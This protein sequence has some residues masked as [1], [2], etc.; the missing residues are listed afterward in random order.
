MKAI[1][2]TLSNTTDLFFKI[3][4]SRGKNITAQF[5]KAFQEN[6]DIALRIAQWARDAR[7]G[8]GERE[9]YRQVL[10]HLEQTHTDV[11]LGTRLLE[12]TAEI[13]RWDDLLIFTNAEVKA[14]AFGMI[15]EALDSGNGLCAKWMPRKGPIALEL[16]TFLGWSPKYYRKRLV[17]LT[18]VVETQMCAKKWDEINFSHVPSLA[19]SRYSKAFGKNASDSFT[20]FKTKLKSGDKSVKVNAGAVYPYDITKNVKYGDSGLADEQWKA[21]PNFIGDAMVLPL[22]D[23]SGSMTT[24]A[25]G[26]NS[27]SGV[28]CLDVAV[29]LGLYCSDKNTGPFKDL[30]LTFSTKPKF[31][32]LTGTLSQK[33]KQMNTSNWE[34]STNLHGAF[35]EI[36][37]VAKT[38]DVAAKDMPQVLLIMSDMQFNQCTRFD[39]SAMQMIRRKYKDAGYETPQVVF[40]NL[41]AA[42]NVPVKF[43]EKGVALV[44]GF[45]PSIMKSV[46]AADMEGFTP[47]GIMKKA[48][49]SDRYAL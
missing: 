4:A 12:N 27:K 3:G 42:D 10:K 32:H 45:S 5:E 11:L 49:M 24:P 43:D 15:K 29:S 48:V 2:S 28:S 47:E 16:R 23:V 22:V 30:F 7:G 44:S 39:D 17:E 6:P 26:Y 19:M 46:L 20:E 9:L 37:R 36:L 21:L 18:K 1:E 41:N 35:E 38:N 8:A 13:G 33:I 14:K 25:G 40:W 34:M 31:V